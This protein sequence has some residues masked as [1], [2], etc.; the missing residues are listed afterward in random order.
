MSHADGW[1]GGMCTIDNL[2]VNLSIRRRSRD[3]PT[4]SCPEHLD[5]TADGENDRG[6]EQV[7]GDPNNQRLHQDV[8]V[9]GEW[10][11]QTS[12]PA[13]NA[14]QLNVP[15]MSLNKH[16]CHEASKNDF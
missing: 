3:D 10:T 15:V 8:Q 9:K 14:W 4:A 5:D 11:E 13:T 7:R 2:V 12:P 1:N 6:G 16:Q